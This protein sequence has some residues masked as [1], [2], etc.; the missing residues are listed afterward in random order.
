MFYFPDCVLTRPNLGKSLVISFY[1]NLAMRDIPIIP[2][3]VPSFISPFL[4]TFP[5]VVISP[6]S[7]NLI[8]SLPI[9]MPASLPYSLSFS[10]PLSLSYFL[11]YSLPSSLPSPLQ[12]YLTG[13]FVVIIMKE[14]EGFV[15]DKTYVEN[16]FK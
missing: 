4:S 7:L 6:F 8:L 12:I 16:I 5:F 2:H 13:S 3:V 10:L 15:I 11:H 1:I 14:N 9:F